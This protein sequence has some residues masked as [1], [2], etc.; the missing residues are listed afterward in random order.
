MKAVRPALCLVRHTYLLW[1]AGQL[2]FRLETFGLYYPAPPYSVS[3]WK[4]PPRNMLL[5]LRRAPSYAR[6]LAD[7]VG[8]PEVPSTKWSAGWLE[9][10]ERQ[11]WNRE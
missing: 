10:I 3:W 4:V 8:G 5:L 1:R 2:R 6:W 7:M 11:G 9:A